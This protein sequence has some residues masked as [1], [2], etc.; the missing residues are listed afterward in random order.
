MSEKRPS[1]RQ[2]AAEAWATTDWDDV[3]RFLGPNADRFLAV[4]Q[5]TREKLLAKGTGNAVGWSW[6]AFVFSFA[7]FLYRKQWVAGIVL[8]AAPLTIVYLGASPGGGIGVG[9]VMAI[10]AKSFLLQDAVLKIARI[11][12]RGGG[13]AEVAAAGGVSRIGGLI[14]GIVWLLSAAAVIVSTVLRVRA[15]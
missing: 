10:Y 12:S 7:W 6:S 15:G 4:W 9:I 5:R 8:I 3:A 13:D 1:K 2:Q 11:R 14:G